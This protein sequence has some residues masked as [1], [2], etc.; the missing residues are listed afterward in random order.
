MPVELPD[1]IARRVQVAASARG[2]S[3]D[4]VVIQAVEAHLG[5]PTGEPAPNPFESM[6]AELQ[7]MVSDGSLRRDIDAVVDDPELA[8]G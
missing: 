7:Q 4:Q 3:A 6:L 5:L 1:E 8:V 2:I